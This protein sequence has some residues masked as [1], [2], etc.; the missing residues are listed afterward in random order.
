[1]AK[2]DIVISIPCWREGGD[3]GDRGDS[4]K[5]FFGKSSKKW[6]QPFQFPIVTAA[7][8]A[9]L[10]DPEGFLVFL[11]ILSKNCR[12]HFRYFYAERTA[13]NRVSCVSCVSCVSS[14]SKNYFFLMCCHPAI[15]W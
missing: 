13:T 12:Y 3:R 6:I 8:K 10:K 4:K 1:M 7:K 5:A 15:W 9:W 2:M 11:A 14:N